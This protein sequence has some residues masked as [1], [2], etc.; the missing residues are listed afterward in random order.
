MADPVDARELL[1]RFLDDRKLN[2]TQ[3]AALAKLDRPI[4]SHY[5]AG[6]RKPGLDAAFAIE[7]ATGGLVPAKAWS[8]QEPPDTKRAKKRSR[9]A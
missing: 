6:T 9:A 2:H 4:V 8:T 7:R 3:F 1:N 5:C